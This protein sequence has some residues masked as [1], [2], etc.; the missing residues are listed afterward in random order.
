M[1]KFKY[2]CFAMILVT[3][4]SFAMPANEKQVLLDNITILLYS[5]YIH[6]KSYG[7]DHTKKIKACFAFN[8]VARQYDRLGFTSLN[9]ATKLKPLIKNKNFR[10]LYKESLKNNNCG[11]LSSAFLLNLYLL[12][13]DNKKATAKH[14][15]LLN[16]AYKNNITAIGALCLSDTSLTSMKNKSAYCENV[17]NNPNANDRTK[18][19]AFFNLLKS[20]GGYDTRQVDKLINL[21]G[22]T[23]NQ[24]YIVNYKAS[25]FDMAASLANKLYANKKYTD[26]FKI[27]NSIAAFYDPDGFVTESIGNMY[28][29]GEGVAQNLNKAFYWYKESLT[30]YPGSTSVFIDINKLK[31]KLEKSSLNPVSLNELGIIYE[32]FGNHV[33]AFQYYQKAAIMGSAVSQLNLAIMYARGIGVIQDD[34]KAYAWVA[35]AV[36][37]GLQD[38]D[39]QHAA[40]Q[41]RSSL[42]LTLA[43]QDKNG[44]YLKKAKNLANQYYNLY[45]LHKKS[46][47]NKKSNFKSRLDAAI[48]AFK[49]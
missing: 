45:V 23:Y 5:S 44:T 36:A 27:Y 15:R 21:C 40:E 6:G 24:K 12:L 1:K 37:Q 22:E 47:Q 2:F 32:S 48:K 8:A 35:V 3:S 16:F 17:I 11:V 26:A 4:V 41:L 28:R 34:I 33:H 43:I 42:A 10:N 9:F 14:Q 49:G 29:D 25:C 7:N 19:V 20:Y 46:K 31:N 18:A 13:D 38:N 39:R 30:H